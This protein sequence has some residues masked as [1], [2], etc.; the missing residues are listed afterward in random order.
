MDEGRKGRDILCFKELRKASGRKGQFQQTEEQMQ[1]VG[2]HHALDVW[3]TR[4][5]AQL[6][7]W[8]KIRAAAGSAHHTKESRLDSEEF[9]VEWKTQICILE[10]HLFYQI[11]RLKGLDRKHFRLCGA[12]TILSLVFLFGLL[13]SISFKM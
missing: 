11:R 9:Q 12:H 8:A 1:R 2:V 7:R 4:W 13:L 6:D 5:Q 10:D 3:N